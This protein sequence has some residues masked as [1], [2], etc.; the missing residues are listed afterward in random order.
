M[1]KDSWAPTL[2]LVMI[3]SSQGQDRKIGVRRG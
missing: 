3:S 2:L 1:I